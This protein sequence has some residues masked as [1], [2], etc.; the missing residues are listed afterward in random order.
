[1]CEF[2]DVGVA[3]CRSVSTCCPASLKAVLSSAL[4]LPQSMLLRGMIWAKK[5]LLSYLNIQHIRKYISNIEANHDLVSWTANLHV[6]AMYVN[7]LK[8]LIHSLKYIYIYI[9]IYNVLC[10]RF[11][12]KKQVTHFIKFK[13]EKV[14]LD[15]TTE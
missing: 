8:E 5:S 12:F 9:Y 3:I 1:M 14:M 6:L 13:E 7:T 2:H 10:T 11:N 15:S 4:W